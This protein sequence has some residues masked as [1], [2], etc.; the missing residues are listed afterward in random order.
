MADPA[1]EPRFIGREGEIALLEA[2]LNDA[3]A[4]RSRTFSITGEPGIGKT[5]LVEEFLYRAGLP[6]DDVLWGRCPEGGGLPAY[7]PWRQALTPLIERNPSALSGEGG[8]AGARL[9]AVLRQ[10][11]GEADPADR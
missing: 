2:G 9:R 8:P 10:L 4:G 5:R 6:E 7:W 3:R 11:G 1:S